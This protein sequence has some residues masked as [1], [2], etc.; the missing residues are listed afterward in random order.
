MRRHLEIWL[1]VFAAVLLTGVACS[2]V[3]KDA[4]LWE[5]DGGDSDTDTDSDSDTD[6]DSD[7]GTAFDCEGDGVWLDEESGLCWQDPPDDTLKTWQD[8]S[9]DCDEL[10]Q[11]G[12]DDWRMPN[13][14]ELRS[15]VQGCPPTEPDG[16]CLVQD[17]SSSGDLNDPCWGCFDNEFGG[18]GESGCYWD[19]DLSGLC[20]TRCWSASSFSDDEN[21][22]WILVFK[23]ARVLGIT[24]DDGTVSYSR[25]VRNGI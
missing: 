1:M 24:W 18:P 9:D 22:V 2:H 3:G 5:P 17:G 25:C 10:E 13:I 8:A 20:T 19:P 23:H 7:T 21:R 16:E 11:D 6:T 15:L 12:Y 14:D 4:V